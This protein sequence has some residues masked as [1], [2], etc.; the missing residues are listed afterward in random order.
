MDNYVE[1]PKKQGSG[2]HYF[3]VF[4]S[5]LFVGVML[6]TA[7]YGVYRGSDYL[8]K[9]LCETDE[10]FLEPHEIEQNMLR[11][12]EDMVSVVYQTEKEKQSETYQD[13][14]LSGAG[15]EEALYNMM[16]I[17]D[18]GYYEKINYD[19]IDYYEEESMMEDMGN[20]QAFFLDKGP[21]FFYD[22]EDAYIKYGDESTRL[23]QNEDE[24][25]LLKDHIE[26]LKSVH[27]FSDIRV[28]IWMDVAYYNEMVDYYE[29]AMEIQQTLS[30]Y[31]PVHILLSLGI[32][33]IFLFIAALVSV[34]TRA[35]MRRK[36]QI[37]TEI[38]LI[39]IGADILAATL[40]LCY[41]MDHFYWYN[42][43]IK[44]LLTIGAGAA[45]LI[46]YACLRECILKIKER[47][48]FADSLFVKCIK[49]ICRKIRNIF[50]LLLKKSH[51][52]DFSISRKLWIRRIAFLIFS[53]IY[54]TW[55]VLAY[56]FMPGFL[57]FAL[58]VYFVL[59]LLYAAWEMK[60]L[61]AMNE[62]YRQID[63]MSHGEY[64]V[65]DVEEKDPL[66]DVKM[67]L[68]GLSNGM[69]EAVEKRISSEKMKVELITNVSHD[70]KTP[71]TSIISYVNLLKEEAMSE[72]A[73][74]YV[75]ILE[76]KADKLKNIVADVFELAKAN[77]GQDVQIETIDGI[78]LIHQVLADMDDVIARSGKI[79]KA[80]IQPDTY[81]IKGDG[82][83]LYRALQ[84]LIDN[85][86]KYSMEGTRIYLNSG[87]EQEKLRLVI[88]NI[89]SY[90]MDFSGEDIVERFVRG[91]ESRTTEG[92]GLGL[93]IA[94]SFIEVSGGS[95]TVEVDGDVFKVVVEF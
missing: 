62:V 36:K 2:M 66:Y 47:R 81:F 86:L 45:M 23:Y 22:G 75:K 11:A 15:Y 78:M 3:R 61:K 4:L 34:R 70:L 84:N 21:A 28:C 82:R 42:K 94:K 69:E 1:T 87:V 51:Y 59:C 56:N 31:N 39:V 64:V 89:A 74:D 57:L 85:A 9:R 35:G 14:V 12:A 90:E 19:G 32:S 77:S 79:I 38:P 88:K 29:S 44:I 72:T 76:D 67:K 8:I 41:V 49:W 91:D 46:L 65:W 37:F 43:N 95:M 33:V 26:K 58:A 27:T 52:E 30:D 10:T 83:K 13:S 92:N 18:D 68:N 60:L 80:D 17:I 53:M 16:V 40:S 93:S 63:E 5:M 25:K 6:I 24:L 73:K 20:R 71:L 50:R 54:L 7:C 48:F 55:M